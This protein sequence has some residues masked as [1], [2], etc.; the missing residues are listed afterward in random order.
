MLRFDRPLSV[1]N[2]VGARVVGAALHRSSRDLYSRE[3][4]RAA[5]TSGKRRRDEVAGLVPLARMLGMFPR[6]SGD[7]H[8]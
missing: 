1:F 8:G 4:K 7:S 2:Q 5:V 6:R 3:G